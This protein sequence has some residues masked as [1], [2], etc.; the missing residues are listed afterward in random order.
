M[1]RAWPVVTPLDELQDTACYFIA[2]PFGKGSFIF[3]SKGLNGKTIWSVKPGLAVHF[4]GGE[5]LKEALRK[6][7]DLVAIKIPDDYATRWKARKRKT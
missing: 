2:K 5:K 6:F 3:Y 1:S 4:K 7:D